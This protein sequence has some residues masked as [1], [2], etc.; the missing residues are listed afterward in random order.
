MLTYIIRRVLLMIPTLLG[1][2][3]LVFMLVALAPGGIGAALK[4]SGGMLQPGS[5]RAAQ[6]AY[7]EDR[8]GLDAPAPVQYIR[9]LARIS[10]IKFGQQDQVLPSGDLIRP[11][12]DLNE[13]PKWEWFTEKL[14]EA[15]TNAI[16]MPETGS[17]VERYRAVERGNSDLRG[18][19]IVA[20]A[21]YK[22]ALVA[23]AKATKNYSAVNGDGK[24][25]PSHLPDQ[26]DRS[27]SEWGNVERT[28][29]RTMKAYS[30]A[31]A[32][33]ELLKEAFEAKPY[34][35]AGFAIIPGVISIGWP[36]FGFAYSRTRPVTALL[37][38]ALPVTL[39]LNLTAFPIIYLVAIPAGMLASA[40]RGTWID[41]VLGAKFI[42]LWSFPVVL[43]GVLCLGFLAS[44]EYLGWFPSN[45]LHDKMAD[46]FALLPSFTEAGFERGY[47]LDTLWH[48]CLPVLCL[49]Y[50]QFALL[51]KQTRAA[52]LDNSNADYVRTARAKG[53]ASRDVLF[54][55]IFRNSLLP[56]I[57][58]FV[59]L[60]PA[61]LAGSVIVERIFS[62]PGMG[63]LT[64]EA[65][66]LR[67]RE[68]LLANTLMIA[69][70]NLF[71]L[72]LAD[73]LYAVADPRISYE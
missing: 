22:E 38:E 48:M 60:F 20:A 17:T 73:I 62:V 63:W 12:K 47:L 16:A 26:P 50:G 7:L 68:L 14:P 34:P 29:L 36:D 66:N 46:T 53:V 70:V 45:A 35:E 42:V 51:S 56:L 24:I 18:E 23:Y 4:A 43:A 8:Y 69:T 30:A 11:P 5:S 54:R 61:I 52:M 15:D 10:P 39:L 19:Y 1:I 59:S 65:I 13:P 31:R 64:I 2:T 67:D 41:S 44:K 72:L 58:M 49:V 55:H 37:G 71:A 33:Q 57:T 40:R 27:S 6:E 25:V 32:G 28:G 9:W 21:V 3:F